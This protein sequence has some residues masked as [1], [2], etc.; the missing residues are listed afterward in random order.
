M[1]FFF[2]LPPETTK[3]FVCAFPELHVTLMMTTFLLP[4][5]DAQNLQLGF[6]LP[7]LPIRN[8]FSRFLEHYVSININD[9]LHMDIYLCHSHAPLTQNIF[10]CVVIEMMNLHKT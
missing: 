6:P 8:K 3:K 7:E 5:L 2:A 10:W 1:S 4:D 9:F